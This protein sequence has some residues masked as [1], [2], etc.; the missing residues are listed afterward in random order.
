MT[1]GLSYENKPTNVIYGFL[2]TVMALQELFQTKCIVFCW[3]SKSSKRKELFSGYKKKRSQRYKE[4]TPKEFRQEK[5]FRV[6][7]KKLRKMYLK[8]IG[9]R[10]VFCQQGYEADDLMASVAYNLPKDDEAVIITSDQDLLQCVRYNVSF[11]DP[12]KNKVITLQKFS[13]EHGII[14]KQWVLMKCYAGCSTDEVPGIRG[15]GEKTAIKYIQGELR[16]T[17][18]AYQKIHIE[19]LSIIEQNYPLVCLPFEDTKVFRL[20]KDKLSLK[21]WQKVIEKLGMKSLRKEIPMTI[22]GRRSVNKRNLL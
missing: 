5:A 15:I 17:T 11:Y 21:G 9:Y 8:Q 10:N 19:G 20:K 1:G 16:D 22:R 12:R 4:W 18:K 13:K 3:D 2:R 14:P 6:Q 7:M